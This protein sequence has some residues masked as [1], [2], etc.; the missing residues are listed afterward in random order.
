M[1]VSQFRS[2]SGNNH[3]YH[4]SVMT[5]GETFYHIYRLMKMFLRLRD[6]FFKFF[7]KI[8]FRRCRVIC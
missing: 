6:G 7:D 8:L 3:D 2:P 1:I 5:V 4:D